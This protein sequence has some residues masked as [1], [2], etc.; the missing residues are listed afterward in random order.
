MRNIIYQHVLALVPPHVLTCPF[1]ATGKVIREELLSL[2]VDSGC[3]VRARQVQAFLN[4]FTNNSP[5][6]VFQH[7][8]PIIRVEVDRDEKYSFDVLE[9]V[10]FL[11]RFL[12]TR[13]Y[14][15]SVHHASH[16]YARGL[17][18]L[19]HIDR[20]NPAW[21]DPPPQIISAILYFNPSL[22][23]EMSLCIGS[24]PGRLYKEIRER[25]WGL[26]GQ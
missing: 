6:N 25:A 20:Q 3:A 16:D 21:H 9:L 23:H 12:R 4:T 15:D 2:R 14:F 19:I 11:K 17:D 8:A 18:K 26:L 7:R 22:F 13:M 10:S 1:A 5:I 24:Q